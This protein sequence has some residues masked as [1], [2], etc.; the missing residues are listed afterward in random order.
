MVDKTCPG[1]GFAVRRN[2]HELSRRG[3]KVATSGR[4][5]KTLAE[6]AAVINGDILA[7]RADVSLL[8]DLDA[9]FARRTST[10]SPAASSGRSGSCKVEA[11]GPWRRSPAAPVSPTRAILSSFQAPCRRHAAT[12]PAIRKNRLKGGKFRQ[13]T[14]RR[15]V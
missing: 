9:L 4:D 12:V 3:A 2:K 6:A 11:T 8:G 5:E 10:S 7:V 15:T 1:P 13:E 14:G